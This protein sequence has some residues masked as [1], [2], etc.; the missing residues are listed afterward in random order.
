LKKIVLVCLIFIS[1][2]VV[3]SK[4]R[5]NKLI[6][7]Q[8]FSAKRKVTE[9]NIKFLPYSVLVDK[10]KYNADLV[11]L[12][13]MQLEMDMPGF[14]KGVINNKIKELEE[15]QIKLFDEILRRKNNE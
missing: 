13:T 11:L 14:Y 15:E 5:Y 2:C 7:I 8:E 9:K 1:G 3:L 4:N 10:Y 6:T 12:K